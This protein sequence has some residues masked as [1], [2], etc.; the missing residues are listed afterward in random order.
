MA[1]DQKSRGREKGYTE[2]KIKSEALLT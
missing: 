1:L 2:M